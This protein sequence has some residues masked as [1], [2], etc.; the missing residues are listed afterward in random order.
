[1]PN[2][3]ERF[4]CEVIIMTAS[5]HCSRAGRQWV[6][7]SSSMNV[8]C[9]TWLYYGQS[10]CLE[11]W[12]AAMM[13]TKWLEQNLPKHLIRYIFFKFSAK[14]VQFARGICKK[15]SN[16]NHNGFNLEIFLQWVK[17]CRT[18]YYLCNE[19]KKKYDL[20][21][22]SRFVGIFFFKNL[23]TQIWEIEWFL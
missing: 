9:C 14:Q 15:K 23:Y 13:T 16:T 20:F 4:R 7:A 19:N 18:F 1:M 21:L 17:L 3:A 2:I 10:S 11:A 22:F 6:T 8:R 12:V 5:I